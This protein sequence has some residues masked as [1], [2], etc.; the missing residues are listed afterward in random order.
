MFYE[1][2]LRHLMREQA[3]TSATA[4]FPVFFF[5]TL[6]L[7]RLNEGLKKGSRLRSSI[8]LPLSLKVQSGSS[9]HVPWLFF[10]MHVLSRRYFLFAGPAGYQRFAFWWCAFC[11][12]LRKR[13]ILPWSSAPLLMHVLKIVRM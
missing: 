2:I 5:L 12:D 10:L 13:R 4:F 6:L 7:L 11:A 9:T 3:T 1:I 8:R